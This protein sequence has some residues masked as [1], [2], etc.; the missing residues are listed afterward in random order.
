MMLKTFP[1]QSYNFFFYSQHILHEKLQRVQKKAPS[2]I[3]LRLV[4]QSLCRPLP[5]NI[6]IAPACQGTAAV[7]YA[8]VGL[9]DETRLR[10]SYVVR[11]VLKNALQ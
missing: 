2:L 9:K 5:Y 8:I 4:L 11:G 7:V 10:Q 1:V 3:T 6:I